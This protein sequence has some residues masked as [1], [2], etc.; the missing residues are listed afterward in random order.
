MTWLLLLVVAAGAQEL[1]HDKDFT[2]TEG[3]ALHMVVSY[4]GTVTGSALLGRT[5]N[6]SLLERTLIAG[7]VVF[8]VGTGREVFGDLNS[9]ADNIANGLGTFTGMVF[10]MAFDIGGGIDKGPERLSRVSRGADPPC[11]E[12]RGKREVAHCADADRQDRHRQGAHGVSVWGGDSGRQC[13][14]GPQNTEPGAR[15]F[16][17]LEQGA[18][19]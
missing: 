7:G 2:L 16:R 5:T 11:E 14:P 13:G 19:G 15:C 8:L 10:T 6:L 1:Q 12:V 3:R 18:G 9:R 17:G 4:A